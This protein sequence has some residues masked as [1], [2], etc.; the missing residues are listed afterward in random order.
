MFQI[1]KPSDAL[2]L[3]HWNKELPSA[4]AADP[5][6]L[7]LR[8]SARLGNELLHCI[9]SITPR[10]RYYSFF[11]W[12]FQDYNEHEH[13]TKWDRGRI[14]GVVARE[15]AMV[16]G[17]VL[18]HDGKT[19]EGGALG[20]SR[21]AITQ[22]NKRRRSYDLA[23]WQHLGAAEG[24]FGAAYKGSLI[25]LGV[26]ETDQ[27]TVQDE[28]DVDTGELSAETQSIEVRELSALG[29]R[30]ALA[31]ERSIRDTRYVKREW[32]LHGTVSANILK[33]FGSR[34]GLC[35]IASKRATDPDALR[36]IFFACDEELQKPAHHRRRMSLLLLLECVS[37][38][39][40]AD[41]S[42]DNESLGDICYFGS[43][44]A[45]TES[46]PRPVPIKLHDA[47]SDI[48]FRWRVYF[49]QS[50][51]TVALQSFLVTCVRLMRGRPG[52]V[53]Y[54]NLLQGL[55]ELA[56]K[57][58]YRELFNRA[59]PKNFFVMT[60]RETLTLAGVAF[61]RKQEA[62]LDALSVDAKFSERSLEI[63]LTEEGEANE[64]A[65]IVLATMLLYQVVVRYKQLMETPFHN[66]YQQQ[67]Y[68][69]YADISVP[70]VDTFL[71]G[72]FG[73]DWLDR[74]NGEILNRVIW[75]F[76]IRQHQTMSYERGFGGSA[77]L[78][79]VDGTTII[80]TT[81]DFTDPRADNPRLGSAL[82]ILSDL[83][84]LRWDSERGYEQTPK[85]KSW[86]R[87]QI[88]H[89]TMA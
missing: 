37:K 29:K 88:Q 1:T 40:S 89:E 23:R 22:A 66:W 69:P 49:F 32:T 10:A 74:S 36:S 26:F 77:P 48:A 35:E 44:L 55:G 34:A 9:T 43:L 31:F 85:G 78:F 79:H 15:R 50:Y 51:L 67:V 11:P 75:R 64:A 4:S 84:L 53:G 8:V 39:H 46:K 70:G 73:P 80:G 14:N 25:N 82:Q 17:A 72:E 63:L 30:L 76:V 20:G 21:R 12:A 52:G 58:R 54:Q 24:Q 42:L 33:E 27:V 68:D 45:G 16:L 38:A 3:L 19:C 47:L 83:G 57:T 71:H 87:A 62:R 65:G 41:I 13:S 5:L 86:L 2:R 60:A 81:T 18:H 28:V 61:P 59:L 7:N 6:G 56:I